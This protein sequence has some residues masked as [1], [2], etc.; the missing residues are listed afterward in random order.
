MERPGGLRLRRSWYRRLPLRRWVRAR[1]SHEMLTIARFFAPLICL[2]I[3]RKIGQLAGEYLRRYSKSH[4]LEDRRC[5]HRG[6]GSAKSSRPVDPQPQALSHAGTEDLRMTSARL[7]KSLAAVSMP[8]RA[9]RT[10]RPSRPWR[11]S[12]CSKC[13]IAIPICSMRLRWRSSRWA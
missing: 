13:W 7:P 1:L 10:A 8:S 9:T 12:S 11:W 5:S 3:D 4:S 6:V 2:T